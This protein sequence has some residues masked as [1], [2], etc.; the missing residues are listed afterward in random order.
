MFCIDTA[1]AEGW[2]AEWPQRVLQPTPLPVGNSVPPHTRPL[3]AEQIQ[4]LKDEPLS[5]QRKQHFEKNRLM[6]EQLILTCRPL[7]LQRGLFC[8]VV[9]H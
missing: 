1:G 2:P 3:R 6:L 5:Q 4:I 9:L 8:L 7:G